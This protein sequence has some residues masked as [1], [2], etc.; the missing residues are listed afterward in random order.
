MRQRRQIISMRWVVRPDGTRELQ[1]LLLDPKVD[2]AE[3]E[4]VPERT[5]NGRSA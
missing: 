3:W 5:E 1:Q 4:P 2:T